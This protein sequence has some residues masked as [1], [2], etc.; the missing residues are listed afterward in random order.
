MDL[1]LI[2]DQLEQTGYIVLAKPLADELLEGL[3][4][5]CEDDGSRRFQTAHVGRG[6]AKQHIESI[7]GDV[8]SWM[9]PED[10]I[11]RDFLE[12][13]EALR[14]ALNSRLFLGMFDYESHYAIYSKGYGYAKHSDV[15]QGKKNR[16]LTTVLYLNKDW[17]P[18]NGG[19]LVVY[20]PSGENELLRVQPTFGTMIIFLSESYPHEVLLSHTTRRSI[21]GWFRVSGS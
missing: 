13:M 18:E 8:I 5:R 1:D 16:I 12:Q 19:E 21:A 15:L 11:D 3:M 6:P 7:R 10:S 17:Q 9:D 2:A 14:L 4:Q 20:E